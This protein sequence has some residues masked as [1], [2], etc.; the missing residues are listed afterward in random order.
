MSSQPRLVHSAQSFQLP[1]RNPDSVLKDVTLAGCELSVII[2]QSECTCRALLLRM[3]AL[4][5]HEVAR[6]Q[7]AMRMLGCVRDMFYGLPSARRT[8][9]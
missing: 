1:I 4:K 9:A 2:T 5:L 7:N 3:I 8:D 6:L